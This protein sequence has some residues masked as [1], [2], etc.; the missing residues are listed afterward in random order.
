M[1]GTRGVCIYVLMYVCIMYKEEGRICDELRGTAVFFW[2][3]YAVR[4]RNVR[5]EGG[6]KSVG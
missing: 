3:F 4:I 2:C 6:R 5:R 1:T